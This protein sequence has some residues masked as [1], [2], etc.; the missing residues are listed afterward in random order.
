VTFDHIEFSGAKVAD[1]N[2]AGIRYQAG[3]LTITNCYFHNNQEGILAAPNPS[4]TITI[5]HS[6]F[7]YNGYGDGQTHN[8]YIGRIASFTITN[9]YIHDAIVG[10]EVKSMAAI[11]TIENNRIVD[12]KSTASYSIDLPS[13]G[14][15][16]VKNNLI[17]QG[18]NSQNKTIISYGERTLQL[19]A[20]SKLQ[21]ANNTVVNQRA[22]PLFLFNHYSTVTAA[23][24]NN[25]FFG[26][27]AAQ[28][29]SGPNVQSGDAFL[30]VMP[31]IN[32]SHPWATSSQIGAVSLFDAR[33]LFGS[34][35]LTKPLN[36]GGLNFENGAGA[37]AD[38]GANPSVVTDDNL[39]VQP[40][41]EPPALPL[42]A[43]GIGLIVWFAR[44]KR[45]ASI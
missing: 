39:R 12:G 21:I 32:T 33:D 10:H 23:I 8:I 40:I 6:E 34:Q 37:I 30:T 13:G 5:D 41:P 38:A 14:V 11:S 3:N 17:Q 16:V 26:F 43:A 4:G 45:S 22:N 36:P 20:N 2:G 18:P 28:I 44:R 1:K 25:K 9:S 19:W 35:F 27:V 24:T 31:V 15:A 29:A 7:G 42:F